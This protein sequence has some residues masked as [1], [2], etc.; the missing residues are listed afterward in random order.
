MAIDLGEPT[1]VQPSD[2]GRT[3]IKLA[4]AHFWNLFSGQVANKILRFGAAVL[5]A[6]FLTPSSF[7][8][9]NVGIAISGLLVTASALG[10]PELGSRAVAANG[11]AARQLLVGVTIARLIG[12]AVASTCLVIGGLIL[13]SHQPAFY[14]G[15]ICMAVAMAVTPDWL[16]RG[17][18]RMRTVGVATT[19]GG[20]VA[21]LG[22]I[23]AWKTHSA[24]YSL[25]AFA[26]AEAAVGLVCLRGIASAVR[27]LAH[28]L[29]PTLTLVRESW[30]LGI[31]GVITYSY[32]AN[33]DSVILAAFHGT[34]DAGKI[35]K[36]V[37]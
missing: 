6:R 17:L 10:L 25:I 14:V 28:S 32:Y 37:V 24:A 9:F 13:W 12:L 2:T 5:L 26:I 22:A 33:V 4:R 21:C 27:P 15:T 23:T 30:P 34:R 3:Y 11:K 18:E 8:L 29:R 16:A 31:A 35:R 7:G 20:V 1:V 19:V 36:S